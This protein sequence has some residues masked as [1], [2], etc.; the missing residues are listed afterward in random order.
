MPVVFIIYFYHALSLEIGRF[1]S[2]G[3]FCLFVVRFSHLVF[4]LDMEIVLQSNK[5]KRTLQGYINE[6]VI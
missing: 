3:L 5:V 1:F 6:L 2:N 4:F